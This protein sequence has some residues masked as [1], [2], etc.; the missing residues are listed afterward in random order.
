MLYIHILPLLIY[1]V[2]LFLYLL[3]KKFTK[4]ITH[5]FVTIYG[6]AGNAGNCYP[7]FYVRFFFINNIYTHH[8]NKNIIIIILFFSFWSKIAGNGY[9]FVIHF[10]K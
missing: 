2:I 4:K 8:N 5:F 7:F 9:P 1:L 3:L 10:E 6:P